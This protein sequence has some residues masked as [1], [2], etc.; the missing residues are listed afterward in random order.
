[1]R[2]WHKRFWMSLHTYPAGCRGFPRLAGRAFADFPQRACP[3]AGL[4]RSVPAMPPRHGGAC[5]Q[6]AGHFGMRPPPYGRKQ[7]S[8]GLSRQLESRCALP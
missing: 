3:A 7:F 8:T 1:M 6:G 5:L 2:G 4:M